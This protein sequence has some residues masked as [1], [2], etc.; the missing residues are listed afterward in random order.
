MGSNHLA[1]TEI[2]YDYP[3]PKTGRAHRKR[4]IQTGGVW[5]RE[6][7]P[8]R[9]QPVPLTKVV[10]LTPPV[11]TSPAADKPPAEAALAKI[12]AEAE[13]TARVARLEVALTERYVIKRAPVKVGD[14]PL[15]QTEYRYRGDANRIAFTESTFRLA[16]DN[17]NPS[18]ARSMVDV[19]E[20]R[21]WQALRVSGHED[22]KR[23]VWVEASIRGVR[24]LGYEPQAADIDLVRRERESRQ[25]NHIE[26]ALASEA[27]RPGSADSKQSSRGGGRKAVLAALE[28]V[29]VA[30][31][32]PARQRLAV[33]AAAEEKLAKQIAAGQTHRV[34]IYDKTAAPQR[35]A[36][37]PAP[38]QQRT[39]ERVQ[40]R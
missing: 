31:R 17:N 11:L 39:R 15:G 2:S 29:L 40:S 30:K 19:A 12:D 16:T 34:K 4:T 10:A 20:A 33:M 18:V 13:R 37:R 24:A 32:V 1:L 27:D 7:H 21:N 8:D 3:F 38:E 14:V 26:A 6:T 22:F 28:A 35:Q 23:M 36:T 9:P 5:K 25:I